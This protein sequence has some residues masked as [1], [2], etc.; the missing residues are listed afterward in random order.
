MAEQLSRI[1]GCRSGDRVLVGHANFQSNRPAVRSQLDRI[2]RLGCQVRVIVLDADTSSPEWIEDA[3]GR[4]NVRV[5]DD[6]RSKFIVAEARFGGRYR[7]MVWTGTHNLH[8]HA[9]K[10][11]DDN[12]VRVA[13]QG[14]ANL[15][16]QFFQRLWSGA[17]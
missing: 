9:M 5:H 12:M 15:Y 2:Q 8:G 16:G 4:S 13:D 7:A 14:V 10:H 11:A 1:T 17:R 6:L 3:L